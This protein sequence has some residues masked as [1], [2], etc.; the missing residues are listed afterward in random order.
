MRTVNPRIVYGSIKGFDRASPYADL[1]AFDAIAQA[2]GGI[3]SITGEPDDPP[4]K[5]GPSFGDTGT[6]LH[7]AI[8]ILAA[9]LQRQTTG[10]G[11][12]VRVS[13]QE[14]MINF[15]RQ[16]FSRM[17][18]DTDVIPRRGNHSSLGS[19]P[20]DVFPC[21]PS[22]P[23]DYVY[24]YT[25][26][27]GSRMWENLLSATGREDLLSDPRFATPELRGHHPREI[28]DIVSAWTRTRTK[29]EVM[30]IVGAGGVPVGAGFDSRDL[31]CNDYLRDSGMIVTLD[32]PQR[33]RVTILG[34]PVRMSGSH[35]PPAI[36]RFLARTR[37]RC[38]PGFS[39]A[40]PLRWRS[41]GATA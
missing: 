20:A 14:A 4:L 27:A 18:A 23:N 24:L 6:C 25:S 31:Y 39:A 35:V 8:G 11:Q 16:N 32:H 26:R 13:M 28:Y 38:S 41:S 9:L 5:P 17:S 36:A 33:G 2:T 7:L 12:L 29:R 1:L 15:C 40:P 22:G 3:L 19:G 37:M 21:A 10:E 34:W 30:E